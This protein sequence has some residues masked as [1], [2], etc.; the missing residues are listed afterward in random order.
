[1]LGRETRSRTLRTMRS[2]RLT[3]SLYKIVFQRWRGAVTI[4]VPWHQSATPDDTGKSAHIDTLRNIGKEGHKEDFCAAASHSGYQMSHSQTA[5]GGW[6]HGCHSDGDFSFSLLPS[7][8]YGI[9][10][11]SP[12]GQNS[13]SELSA[14][15]MAWSWLPFPV[16]PGCWE[17]E[18]SF[19]RRQIVH[20]KYAVKTDLLLS[21]LPLVLEVV[22]PFTVKHSDAVQGADN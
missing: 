3:T 19:Q 7:L 18:N 8:Q 5:L 10:G 21:R 2:F 6:R 17:E 11:S 13:S 22:P 20:E 4:S 14:S 15:S 16:S 9:G 1:M 12:A